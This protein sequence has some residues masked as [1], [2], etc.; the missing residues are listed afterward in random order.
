MSI[1]FPPYFG[2]GIAQDDP[3]ITTRKMCNNDTE[4]R[5]ATPFDPALHFSDIKITL[6][7]VIVLGQR[8]NETPIIMYYFSFFLK[9]LC[10]QEPMYRAFA[11]SASEQHNRA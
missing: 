1:I 8:S 9:D 6:Q 7:I 4:I 11:V 5:A 10:L 2:C 3:N